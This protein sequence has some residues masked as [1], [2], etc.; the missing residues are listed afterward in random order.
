MLLTPLYVKFLSPADQGTLVLLLLFGTV[1]KIMFR[2]GLDAG[3]LRVYYEQKSD[4]DKKSFTFTVAAFAAVA[5]T[6]LFAS[7]FAAAPMLAGWLFG[8]GREEHA[9][10][11][12]LAAADVYLGTFAFVPLA[13]LR[14]QDR[15]GTFATLTAGRNLLNTVLKVVL[16]VRGLGVTGVLWSDLAA[17]GA[18]SLALLPMLARGVRPALRVGPLGAALRFGLP[19]A[20]HGLMIQILNLGDRKVLEMFRDLATVG[21]YDK[22]YV[23]G[24]GVKFALSAFEPA[25]Q[26]FVYGQVGKPDAAQ[27]LARIVTYAWAGFVSLG[28]VVAVFGDELLR[29]LTFTNPAFWAGAP[30]VPVVV[31]AYLFH[32][33][34]LLTSIGIGISRDT[35]YYPLITLAAAIT[36]LGANF[37]LIP[38]FG[39]L[40]A[41]W[42]TALSY[43]VM[44]AL[45]SF[46]SARLYPIPFEAGRLARVSV[47]GLIAFLVSRM[48]P[49]AL[50]AELAFKS[51][52]LAVFPLALL[53]SGFLSDAERD[54]LATRRQGRAGR[55]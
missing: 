36:S 31:L 52:C 22:A 24:A 10:F 34:F 12:R 45:G 46:F 5:G 44:A 4:A 27:T 38:S 8:E 33:A 39:M 16:L 53:A 30:V 13:L 17:T 29:A 11:V 2:L 40:G 26:P 54:W 51:A 18:W 1:A 41:A 6:A 15:A 49:E 19:K 55:L 21:I 23:L 9:R 35:R 42:A 14:I 48:A 50:L 3:F 37:A 28:L 47:A 7:V 25:W 32:G 20:P 43:A